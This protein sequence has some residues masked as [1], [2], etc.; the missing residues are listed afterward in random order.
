MRRKIVTCFA[1]L[2][3]PAFLSGCMILPLIPFIPVAGAAYQG[4]VIWKL[5]T[6]T[7]YYAF[8]I[9]T[10]Y[11]AVMKASDQ[12]KIEAKI[13]KE[14]PKEGYDLETKGD[15]PMKIHIVPFGKDVTKLIISI[16]TFGDKRYVELFYRLVDDNLPKK[17]ETGK[18]VPPAKETLPQSPKEKLPESA[19]RQQPSPQNPKE[20]DS[21]QP[22]PE[23]SNRQQPPA[24]NPAADSH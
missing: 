2:F 18:E 24:P 13:I 16:S 21:K 23:N 4:Y 12:L 15:V 7:K 11:Q 17:V 20:G 9:L 10:T 22:P 5:G 1:L 14:D 8:D 19:D 6:A 3:F